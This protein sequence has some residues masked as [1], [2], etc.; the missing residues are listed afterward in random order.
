[1]VKRAGNLKGKLTSQDTILEAYRNASAHRSHTPG[2]MNFRKNEQQNLEAVRRMLEDGTYK[3]SQYRHFERKERGKVRKIAALPFFPDRLVHWAVT[4]TT[5][6]IFV[7]SFISQTYA[8]IPGRGTHKA[9]TDLKRALRDPKAIYCAKFD[10]HHFFESIDKDIMMEK[11]ERRIKDRTV[12]DLYREII[13]GYDGPGL[14]IGNLTSQYLANLYLSDIDHFFKEE[15]HA[16]YYFR[17]MDDIVILGWS[18]QWLHRAKKVLERKLQEIGLHLNRRWQIFPIAE[19]G[20][21]FVGYRSWSDHTLLRN[22]TKRRMKGRMHRI[23]NTV[24]K[25]DASARS[26]VAS[27]HGILQWCDGW[28]LHQRYIEPLIMRINTQ[29][30]RA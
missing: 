28:R 23:D 17:Y 22:G 30:I 2:V 19:R 8:A 10:V 6:D 11:V 12:L 21:D 14:P 15:C 16:L 18:A 25:L 26:C 1:M 4:L 13:F 20:V 3:T 24:G 29:E 7:R 27:Y 5:K 9:L